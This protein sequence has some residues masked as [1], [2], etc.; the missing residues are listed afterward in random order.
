MSAN[1]DTEQLGSLHVLVVDEDAG[2]LRNACGRL[3]AH[4]YE[5][6]TSR[7][8]RGLRQTIARSCPDLVLVDVLMPDLNGGQLVSLL[9]QYP[10]SGTPAVI[11][12]SA[13]PVKALCR[14]VDVRDALGVIKK[15]TDDV[16]F[17][18]A[19]DAVLDRFRSR[20]GGFDARPPRA[21]SGTHRIGSD[22]TERMLH[23]GNVALWTGNTRR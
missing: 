1:S 11:L 9:A 15:T 3:L 18:L 13:V 12:H 19:F 22:D 20:K 8:A 21:M 17:F 23:P 2:V 14:M 5:V 7:Q 6:S 16:E 4:G 10:A